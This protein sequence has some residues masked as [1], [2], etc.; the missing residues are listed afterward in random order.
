MHNADLRSTLNWTLYRAKHMVAKHSTC[1]DYLILSRVKLKYFILVKYG[2][3]NQACSLKTEMTAIFFAEVEYFFHD[4]FLR[5]I[6]FGT[7]H[8]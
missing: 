1:S 7:F 6:F 4:F 2:S 5:N 3:L 8:D